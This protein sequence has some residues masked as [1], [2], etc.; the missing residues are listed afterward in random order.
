MRSIAI[1]AAIGLAMAGCS[2]EYP[3]L[4]RT[5]YTQNTVAAVPHDATEIRLQGIVYRRL[6]GLKLRQAIVGKSIFYDTTGPGLIVVT[7]DGRYFNSDGCGYVS[8]RHHMEPATGTYTVKDD[9]VCTREDDAEQWSCFALFR[10]NEGR[11]LQQDLSPP[12]G[13]SKVVVKPNT[14]HDGFHSCPLIEPR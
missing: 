7:G 6:T 3:E 13:P 14:M 1:T 9:R 8:N 12:S 5:G 2:P 4:K 11:L 10:D